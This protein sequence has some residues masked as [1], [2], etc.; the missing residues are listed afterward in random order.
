MTLTQNLRSDTERAERLA[1]L[2]KTLDEQHNALGRTARILNLPTWAGQMDAVLLDHGPL[3][4]DMDPAETGDLISA[5]KH[6]NLLAT[7]IEIGPGNRQDL[8]QRFESDHLRLEPDACRR[9][10]KAGYIQVNTDTKV[11]SV[12][13]AIGFTMAT[14]EV[15]T[16]DHPSQNHGEA[17]LQFAHRLFHQGRDLTPTGHVPAS[18]AS[19]LNAV[20]RTLEAE[21]MAADPEQEHETPHRPG[22]I[23]AVHVR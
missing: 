2:A 22:W 10:L 3:P 12:H 17:I 18:A 15:H 19:Y 23:N 7:L 9:L 4:L 11:V 1:Q 8:L 14:I 16:L 20:G 5:T 6:A 21:T 13:P